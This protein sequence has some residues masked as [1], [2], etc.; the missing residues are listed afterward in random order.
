M[1]DLS[2]LHKEI[3]IARMNL[4]KSEKILDS[5]SDK[6]ELAHNKASKSQSDKLNKYATELW[7]TYVKAKHVHHN[8]IKI[9]STLENRLKDIHTELNRNV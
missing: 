7:N 3:S 6:W 2:L 5:T 9:L 1:S 8:N 4:I